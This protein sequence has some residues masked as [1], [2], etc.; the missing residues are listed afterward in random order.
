MVTLKYIERLRRI[1]QLI[2]QQRTGSA[3][4]LAA[5]MG[6]SRRQLY[7]LIEEL[8]EFGLPVCFNRSSKTF[9][10]EYNCKLEINIE[11]KDL[12]KKEY[13]IYEG[14]AIRRTLKYIDNNKIAS[15]FVFTVQ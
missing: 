12:D 14:G 6:I 5:R 10:Y 3:L 11:V 7:N 2:R 8:K 13:L 15:I 1:D 4:E 9:F